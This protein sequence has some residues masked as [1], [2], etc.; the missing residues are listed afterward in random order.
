[1]G[2]RFGAN[3]SGVTQWWIVRKLNYSGLIAIGWISRIVYRLHCDFW[4]ANSYRP[5]IIIMSDRISHGAC[6]F[7]PSLWSPWRP[8]LSNFLLTSM[9]CWCCQLSWD[10]GCQSSML[11]HGLRWLAERTG[12]WGRR[13][14]NH[15]QVIVE[16][17]PAWTTSQSHDWHM[18][19]SDGRTLKHCFYCFRRMCVRHA[20][21]SVN[22]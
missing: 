14:G 5:S 22:K 10:G 20:L 9:E 16:M 2:E 4:I 18:Q 7:G 8:A 1:M 11:I 3:R 19:Q 12:L 13:F 17:L 21:L 15:K 6:V